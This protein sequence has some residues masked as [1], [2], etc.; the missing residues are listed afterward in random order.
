M[1]KLTIKNPKK[2]AI[3]CKIQHMLEGHLEKSSPKVKEATERGA[4]GGRHQLNPTSKLL[5][6][7]EVPAGGEV[8]LSFQYGVKLWK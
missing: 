6:E 5:W 4:G 8:V 2:A 1:G 7:L 3:K